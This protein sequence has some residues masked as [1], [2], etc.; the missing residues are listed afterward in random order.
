[1]RAENGSFSLNRTRW[2]VWK[3]IGERFRTSGTR[4]IIG[5]ERRIE[6]PLPR[7]AGFFFSPRNFSQNSN[8]LNIQ[9][10][11]NSDLI[12]PI[13]NNRGSLL[14]DAQTRN[15]N[16]NPFSNPF[17]FHN[18]PPDISIAGGVRDRGGSACGASVWHFCDQMQWAGPYTLP[19]LVVSW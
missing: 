18:H 7:G 14:S 6:W 4:W 12:F 3:E 15:R 17:P 19:V 13:S 2:G 10:R 8:R 16:P 5:Q 11:T 1:M 9:T